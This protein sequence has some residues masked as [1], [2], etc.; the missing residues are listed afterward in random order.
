MCRQ[1]F[2]KL[3]DIRVDR[4]IQTYF[5]DKYLSYQVSMTYEQELV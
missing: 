2:L 1:Y 4:A 5:T 3:S